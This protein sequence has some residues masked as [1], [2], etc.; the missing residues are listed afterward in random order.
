M[1]ATSPVRRVSI[2]RTFSIRRCYAP[3]DA[4]PESLV[5]AAH[6]RRCLWH[7]SG[8]GVDR[9]PMHGCSR[10]Y[11]SLGQTSRATTAMI[12]GVSLTPPL[13]RRI[14]VW[15]SKLVDG[16]SNQLLQWR[17]TWLARLPFILTCIKSPLPSLDSIP[18]VCLSHREHHVNATCGFFISVSLS[19]PPSSPRSFLGQVCIHLLISLVHCDSKP[20]QAT[21]ATCLPLEH[22]ARHRPGLTSQRTRTPPSSAPS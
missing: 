22:G 4:T 5:T 8:A 10:C 3:H 18:E 15:N 11:S 14:R 19:R 17:G 1:E 9:M 16:R 7:R 2:A 20:T 13:R 6:L 21:P 12:G